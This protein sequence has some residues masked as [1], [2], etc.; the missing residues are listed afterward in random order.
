MAGTKH[1][2]K[3]NINMDQLIPRNK[4]V[5]AV[6]GSELKCHGWLLIKFQIG[7]H[8][9]TRPLYISDKVDRIYFSHQGCLE[10]NIIPLSFPYP[11][12]KLTTKNDIATMM[13]KQVPPT[14]PPPPNPPLLPT[15]PPPPSPPPLPYTPTPEN[16]PKLKTY[17]L[18]QF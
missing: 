11:M 6:G 7:T 12:E 15:S 9:T 13:I 14:N 2:P 5:T 18:K 10:T 3:L 16:I 4:V 1:L 8:V 17:L